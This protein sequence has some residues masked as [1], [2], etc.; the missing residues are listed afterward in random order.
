MAAKKKAKRGGKKTK[1]TKKAAKTAK[2]PAKRKA[3]KEASEAGSRQEAR[4]KGGASVCRE[5]PR[6]G[7]QSRPEVRSAGRCAVN[8]GRCSDLEPRAR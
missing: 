6:G 8:A 5:G 3:C 1:T 7:T 2:K 4:E